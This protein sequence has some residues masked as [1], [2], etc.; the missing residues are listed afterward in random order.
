MILKVEIEK[1]IQDIEK[2]LP[3]LNDKAYDAAKEKIAVLNRINIE[4][5]DYEDLLRKASIRISQSDIKWLDQ[6]KINIRLTENIGRL[7]DE[8]ET[9]KKNI[10]E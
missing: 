9:L 7:E 8:L 1:F 2:K 4:F 3:Q 6:K 10:N 5:M